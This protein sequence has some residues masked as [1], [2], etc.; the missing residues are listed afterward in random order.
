V[1]QESLFDFVV[2]LELSAQTDENELNTHIC[3]DIRD[4]LDCDV[5]V[6]VR[7]DSIPIVPGEK[8]TYF[9]PMKPVD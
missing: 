7:Y 8:F 3:R 5:V 1:F 9:V 6:N 2:Y 4:S